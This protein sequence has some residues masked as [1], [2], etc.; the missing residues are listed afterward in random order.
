M[1]KWLVFLAC[2]VQLQSGAF[3]AQAVAGDKSGWPG[4]LPDGWHALGDDE[5]PLP[6]RPPFQP[7][8]FGPDGFA[9]F[10]RQAPAPGQQRSR[11]DENKSAPDGSGGASDPRNAALAA[12]AAKA[13]T[14]AENLKKAMAARPDPAVARQQTLDELFKRLRAA[15]DPQE[16]SDFAQAIERV[17]MQSRSD[18]ANLLMHR[19]LLA[20]QAENYALASSLLDKIVD[21]EPGWAEAWNQRAT[22]RFRMDDSDG[23]MAD[24]D[25]AIR[26]EPRHFGA[27]TGMG[28]ILQRAGFDKRALEIFNKALEI[29]PQQPDLEK[30]VEK[31]KLDVEGRDL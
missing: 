2:L 25:Q 21:L 20:V 14:R 11:Q 26:L 13:K 30:T 19:A 6:D 10:P 23:A 3:I 24:I 4:G 8:D 28:M 31:L 7:F 16:A 22:V 17:W 18:T 9:Q 15:P 5:P 27:L 29:Y 12:Q 1:R